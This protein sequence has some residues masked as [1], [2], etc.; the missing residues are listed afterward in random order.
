MISRFAAMALFALLVAQAVPARALTLVTQPDPGSNVIGAEI[1]IAAGIDCE[2]TTQNGLAALVAQSILD[3]PVAGQPLRKAIRAHGGS[4]SYVVGPHDVRF[5]LEGL[6]GSY[7]ALISLFSGVLANPDF[8]NAT[9]DAAREQLDRKIAGRQRLAL[10][11]GI[12]MLDRALYQRT[13]AGMSAFGIPETLA[14]QGS[15]DARAFFAAHYRQTDAIVSVAGASQT[16]SPE[17]YR[18]LVANLPQGISQPVAE[19]IPELPSLS[20]QL[21]AHRDVPV[22]WLVAQYAAPSLGS[23]DFGAMLILSAF[24]QRTLADISS[25]PSIATQSPQERGVGSFYNFDARPANVVVYVDGG[26]GDPTRTFSSALTVVNVLGHA[27]LSGDID[28]MKS[29]A[30]GQFLEETASPEDRAWLGAV[31]AA[32][33]LSGDGRE[34]VVAAIRA[35]SSADLQRVATRYLG[36]P[37]IALVL[38]RQ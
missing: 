2:R 11:V 31:F 36:V 38:P 20:H 17:Q 1:V 32:Q 29:Y 13:D 4:L 6:R 15:A 16:L 30:I 8:S 18:A 19:H 28:Q 35:T 9:L 27:K 24:V 5:Y 37:T 7:P 23:K 10:D 25:V 26:L 21:V 3:T 34:R 22:P 14:A 12:D 33:H